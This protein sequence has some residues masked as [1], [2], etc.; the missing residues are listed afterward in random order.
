MRITRNA[1]KL[2]CEYC[3]I[4]YSAKNDKSG[5]KFKFFKIFWFLMIVILILP[6]RGLLTH[7]SNR[8][9]RFISRRVH[10][11]HRKKSSSRILWSLIIH[12]RPRHP[13]IN[14]I[15][16]QI[17]SNFIFLP[18]TTTL[19]CFLQIMFSIETNSIL[20]NPRKVTWPTG[21]TW[22]TGMMWLV[23]FQTWWISFRILEL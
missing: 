1:A 3:S 23:E 8:N 22:S 12:T 19:N 7:P 13:I 20:T 18:Q 16:D 15:I 17:R 14:R 10:L 9:I 21:V 2:C 6:T 5:V 11:P 4:N